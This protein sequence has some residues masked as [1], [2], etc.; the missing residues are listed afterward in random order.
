MHIL[1]LE[2]KSYVNEIL[3]LI[4]KTDNILRSDDKFARHM[5]S[6]GTC[7]IHLAYFSLLVLLLSLL[8]ASYFLGK[9]PFHTLASLC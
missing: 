8:S 4:T 5:I 9:F 3:K 1:E 2:I 7:T 6:L